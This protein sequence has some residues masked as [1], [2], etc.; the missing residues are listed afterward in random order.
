[1]EQPEEQP[2]VVFVPVPYPVFVHV[3]LP[4]P[5]PPPPPP[6]P[7]NQPQN[8][9]GIDPVPD[10][11]PTPNL[12]RPLW[13][14]RRRWVAGKRSGHVLSNALGPV[15]EII[16]KENWRGPMTIPEDPRWSKTWLKFQ[17]LK[18]WYRGCN[19]LKWFHNK[20]NEQKLKVY[21]GIVFSRMLYTLGKEGWEMAVRFFGHGESFVQKN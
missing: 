17:F 15:R 10:P 12:T 13:F 7:P 21:F 3:L 20:V 18:W 5:P 19:G 16:R 1:M 6:A 9:P 11:G 4:P 14:P 2:P 8:P